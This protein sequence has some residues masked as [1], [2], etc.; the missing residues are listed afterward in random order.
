MNDIDKDPLMYPENI[1][2]GLE[3]VGRYVG[4]T[5]LSK[6][7]SNAGVII[8]CCAI[9]MLTALTLFTTDPYYYLRGSFML[10]LGFG[11]F[12]LGSK[13]ISKQG[14]IW[15]RVTIPADSR[16]ILDKLMLHYYVVGLGRDNSYYDIIP[17]SV[18]W[19]V[20]F[21]RYRGNNKKR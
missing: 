11:L 2:P 4:T 1:V 8:S 17:A 10:I 7:L 12:L 19:E 3:V 15:F 6:T 21:H 9:G 14:C 18:D 20:V 5:P 13:R 16:E